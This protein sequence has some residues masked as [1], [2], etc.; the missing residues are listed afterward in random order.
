MPSNQPQNGLKVLLGAVLA[1]GAMGCLPTREGDQPDL[2]GQDVAL[3]ILHTSDIHSRLLP[4][5][6]API[7]TDRDLGLY[8]E[9][10][11]YGGVARL[12]GL[13]K[14][15]R[16]QSNRVIHLDSGDQFEGAPI[17]NVS[18]GEPE[19]RFMSLIQ[20]DAVVIGNH[21]FD[22]GARLFV[23]QYTKWGTYPLL[24]AN[25]SYSDTNTPTS[26]K[27]GTISRPYTVLNVKGLRVGVIG[28]ANISSLNSI[29]EGGNSLQ[30]TPLEQNETARQYIELLKPQTDLLAVVSHA[31]LTEDQEL[32]TGYEAYYPPTSNIDVYTN[33]AKD[34]WTVLETLSDGTKHVFIPGVRD[35][36]VIIGG[37]LHIVLNPSQELVNPAQP[38]RRVVLQHSGAFTKYLGRLDLV[39]HMPSADEKQDASRED[40]RGEVTAHTYHPF[41]IDSIWCDDAARASHA[42]LSVDAFRQAIIPTIQKCQQLEDRETEGMLQPYV[43]AQTQQLAL[44]RIFAF[45][46]KN[47]ERRNSASGG[48]APLGNMTA[49]S[50]RVRRRVEAEFSLTNTLGIRDNLYAGPI[51][52]ED[53]FNVFPF[54]NTINIMYLSG[55]EMHQLFDYTASRSADRGCQSQGQIAGARFTMDCAQALLNL[56]A[57]PCTNASQCPDRADSDIR[58]PWE[59][60]FP[61]GGDTG[62]C[63]APPSYGITVNGKKLD[64][65]ASYKV[66]VNDYI[67]RGGSGFKVLQRNTTRVETGVSLRDG[68]IEYMQNQCTCAEINAG[69]ETSTTGQFCAT[70]EQYND[71]GSLQ[72]GPDNKPIRTYDPVVKGYCATAKTFEDWIANPDNAVAVSNAAS[73]AGPLLT[74]Q[75][76]CTQVAAATNDDGSP[77]DPNSPCASGDMLNLCKAPLLTAGKCNCIDVVIGNEFAC[78]H[79]TPELEGLCQKPTTVPIVVGVGDGRI[80][81]RVK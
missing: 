8:P 65:K 3:T 32:I 50:M 13:I 38:E 70:V 31:G 62:Q 66:A 75:C 64:E 19:I 5:D 25:Y 22:R 28:M 35:L 10:G 56:N 6:L 73:T 43:L 49:E 80:G 14:R 44:A 27:L 34:P 63:Y 39:V 36:D 74:G 46:P 17:F 78:G 40:L 16:A 42:T 51:R 11:P 47:I 71:D 67:A 23:E 81:R 72:L 15:E 20:P 53:M 1:L 57:Y 77:R 9:T 58:S 76:T 68:L 4:Y 60:D 48:D 12:A 7:K 30:I 45:A 41:P 61:N 33:R 21:E 2:S 54:E 24:A 26:N 69:V 37:H 59:C 55:S 79:I 29:V 52:L 18:N